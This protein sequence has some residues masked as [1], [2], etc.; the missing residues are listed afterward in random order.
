[1]KNF[2]GVKDGDKIRNVATG[3]ELTALIW[4]GRLFFANDKSP[5]RMFSKFD[6]AEWELV[7]QARYYWNR[8]K[9][10]GRELCEYFLRIN[11]DAAGIGDTSMTEAE[12]DDE[13]QAYAHEYKLGEAEARAYIMAR[14]VTDKEREFYEKNAGGIIA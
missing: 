10:T 9:M 14:V 5:M 13:I 1:M 4:R 6:P 12:L 11:F 2:D 8:W 7:E 3:E